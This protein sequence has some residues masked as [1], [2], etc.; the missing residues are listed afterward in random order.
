MAAASTQVLGPQ[1]G[2][3]LAP[4]RFVECSLQAQRFAPVLC[5]VGQRQSQ[6]LNAHVLRQVASNF[7]GN[8]RSSGSAEMCLHQSARRRA[9]RRVCAQV[10]E[11]QTA[12]EASVVAKKEFLEDAKSLGSVRLIVNTGLGVLESVTTLEKLFYH[13]MPGLQTPLFCFCG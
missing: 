11:S 3:T 7:L 5:P 4:A 1:L 12:E 2:T 10:T 8:F 6:R 13:P 9:I